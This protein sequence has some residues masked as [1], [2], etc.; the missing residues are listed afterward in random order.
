MRIELEST[1]KV[2]LILRLRRFPLFHGVALESLAALAQ[3]ARVEHFVDGE[4]VAR[5]G[6]AWSGLHLSLE[7]GFGAPIAASEHPDR[8]ELLGALSVLADRPLPCAVTARG[9]TRA[10]CLPADVLFE[11]LEDDFSTLLEVLRAVGRLVLSAPIHTGGLPPEPPPRTPLPALD[12]VERMFLIQRAFRL[13]HSSVTSLAETAR[14]AVQVPCD[15]TRPLWRAG[16]APGEMVVVVAGAVTLQLADGSTRRVGRYGVLGGIDVLTG[17]PRRYDAW[18]EPGSA[19]LWLPA[20]TTM[21][22]FEDHFHV[23]MGLLAVLS[24]DALPA[25]F[26]PG[27]QEVAA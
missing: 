22:S 11:V 9:A 24:Q 23:A 13:T 3:S 2:A 14:S 27:A 18:P 7:G 26:R 19:V 10:L 5:A 21:N 20:E 12:L 15:G 1:G 16:D 17:S 25:F 4:A 8:P 6:E